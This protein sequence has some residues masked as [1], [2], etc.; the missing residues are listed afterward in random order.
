VDERGCAVRA[1]FRLMLIAWRQRAYAPTTPY[2][3]RLPPAEALV[4]A[5]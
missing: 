4:E 2:M 1:L 5:V 3:A